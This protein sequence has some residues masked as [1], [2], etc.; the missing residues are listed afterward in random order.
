MGQNINISGAQTQETKKTL[1]ITN[2][3]NLKNAKR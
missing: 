3:L 1:I 2:F